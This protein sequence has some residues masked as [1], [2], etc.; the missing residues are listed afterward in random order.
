MNA[1]VTELNVLIVEQLPVQKAIKEQLLKATNVVQKP[2]VFLVNT[3]PPQPQQPQLKLQLLHRI[4]LH[5]QLQPLLQK[6]QLVVHATLKMETSNIMVKF[7][8]YLI[9]KHAVVHKILQLSVH[10]LNVQLQQH[11]QKEKLSLVNMKVI[12]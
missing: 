8:P 3:Q 10:Q 4:H 1:Y 5:I 9:V 2:D 6:L 11:A 7:G 12:I